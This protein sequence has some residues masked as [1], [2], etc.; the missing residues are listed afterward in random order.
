MSGCLDKKLAPFVETIFHNTLLHN[1]MLW[2]NFHKAM[3]LMTQWVQIFKI[4]NPTKLHKN[5][6]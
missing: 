1:N 3:D 6:N 5:K 2:I 4:C